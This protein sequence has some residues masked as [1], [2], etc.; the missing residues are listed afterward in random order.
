MS[1]KRQENKA[2][3]NG[4]WS[5]RQVKH[6]AALKFTPRHRRPQ[7]DRLE[8]FV[9]S[10][11]SKSFLSAWK[12]SKFCSAFCR[13]KHGYDH[14]GLERVAPKEIPKDSIG[15]IGELLTACDLLKKGYEVFKSV[16]HQCSCDLIASKDGKLLRIEVK[17]GILNPRNG[18]RSK[19][20]GGNR[21]FDILATVYSDGVRYS[22]IEP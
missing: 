4:S 6:S 9:C 1:N 17:T 12:H 8:H 15:T 21:K 14:D 11:C 18:G 3:L 10:E 22:P 2:N 5:V 7:K 13:K 20:N 16:S 19:P